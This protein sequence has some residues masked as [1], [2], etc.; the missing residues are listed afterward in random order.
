MW[1]RTIV[2][3]P[4]LML[5]QSMAT[6]GQQTIDARAAFD[7]LKGM[8]GNW[9]TI[10]VGR[11]GSKQLTTFK[12]AA[13]GRVL[14]E[15]LDGTINNVYH[16][17]VDKLMLT[18]YCLSGNQPRMRVK[19][20]DDRRIAFEIFDITNQ[21]DPAGYRTTH[22]EI[23]FVSAD[24]VDLSLRGRSGAEGESTQVYQLTRMKS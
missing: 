7:R 19:A 10:E 4:L 22:L 24:R 5:S 17:D 2:V 15:E 13:R 6:V 8:A 16:L 21:A 9:T 11:S 1:G 23:V 14:V 12:L 18:H 3:A 20:A